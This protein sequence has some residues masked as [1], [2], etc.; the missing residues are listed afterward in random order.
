[1]FVIAFGVLG[2]NLL[3]ALM[4]GLSPAQASAQSLD[5][6]Q[7]AVSNVHYVLNPSNPGFLNSVEFSVMRVD[8][9]DPFSVKVKIDTLEWT[10]CS[11]SNAGSTWSCPLNGASV[12][13]LDRI[14]VWAD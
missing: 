10:A 6:R 8:G 14:Q 1:M 2:G 7:A 11:R 12:S 9:S 4:G 3:G 13:D 5:V